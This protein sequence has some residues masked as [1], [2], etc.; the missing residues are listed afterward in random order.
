M[1]LSR[2]LTSVSLTA[3]LAACSSGDITLAPTNIDNST[4]TGGG[5]GGSTNPCASYTVSGATRRGTFDGTNC[6]YDAAFV[7]DTTPF[8]VDVTIPYISGVHIFQSDVVVGADVS[9]GVAPAGG[10]GPKLTIAAGNKIAFTDA[11]DYL[12]V[13]RGARIIADGTA[14]A[15]ITFTGF[16]DAV[17]HTAGPYDVQLWGGIVLNGHGITNNCTDAQRASNACHIEAEGRPS[18]YGGNDNADNS[19]VLRYVVVKHAALRAK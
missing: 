9:A 16:T 4:T 8:M 10:T 11:S 12:L 5:G 7:S 13:N 1:S 2:A 17:T 15:P 6:T 3:V 19:G 14:T 18:F